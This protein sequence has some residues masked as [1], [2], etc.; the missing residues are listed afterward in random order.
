MMNVSE[1]RE[2]LAE[3]PDDA[4]IRIEHELAGDQVDLV[5]VEYNKKYNMVLLHE[6]D[7]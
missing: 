6:T 4:M 5:M 3:I 7:D 2:A 1:L